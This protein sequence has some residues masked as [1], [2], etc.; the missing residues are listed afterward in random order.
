MKTLGECLPLP[1]PKVTNT[2]VQ[3]KVKLE[4]IFIIVLSNTVKTQTVI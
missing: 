4:V 2:K 3:T 1:P